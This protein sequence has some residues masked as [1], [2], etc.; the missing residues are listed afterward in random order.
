MAVDADQTLEVC[1]EAGTADDAIG[2]A[3]RTRPDACIVGWGLPG[4]ALHA[5]HGILEVVPSPI[6]VLANAL[7]VDGL[8]SAMEA[9]AAGLISGDVDASGLRR[10]VRAVLA[11]EVV[12]PRSMLRDLIFAVRPTMLAGLNVSGREAEVLSLLRRGQSTAEIASRLQ[13]SPVTVRRHISNL[14]RKL[15]VEDRA[16]L[17]G[18]TGGDGRH[19][20]RAGLRSDGDGQSLRDAVTNGVS[21]RLDSV[22]QP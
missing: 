6:V 10:V 15:G 3:N 8:L 14:V 19:S 17:V 18:T 5:V 7:D 11:D 4:G 12:V 22:L 9:G 13:M 21:G 20:L 2:E 1:A 16:A